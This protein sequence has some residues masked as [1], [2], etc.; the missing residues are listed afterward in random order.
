MLKG[1]EMQ[2]IRR[3]NVAARP[4]P[5]LLPVALQPV[6]ELPLRQYAH[7]RSEAGGLDSTCKRCSA[8]VGTKTDELSLL[9][10]ER[11]HVCRPESC[12]TRTS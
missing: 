9:D 1:Q 2:K 10:S 12:L 4:H 7:S 6:G 5:H 8:I 11:E 3:K